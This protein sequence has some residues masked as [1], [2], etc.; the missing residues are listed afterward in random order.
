MVDFVNEDK[1]G[2]FYAKQ[3][4]TE[5]APKDGGN[6]GGDNKGGSQDNDNLSDVEKQAADDLLKYPGKTAEEIVLLKQ[7]E[8]ETAEDAAKYPGKTA[9]EIKALKAQ[10]KETAD[11]AIKYPGKTADEIKA[12]KEAEAANAETAEA[13]KAR[14]DKIEKDLKDKI[15]KELGISSP[16]EI[17]AMRDKLNAVPETPEQAAERIK[18]FNTELNAFAISNNLLSAQ[19]IT[20]I[21]TLRNQQPIDIVYKEFE[22]EYRETFKDRK[23]E[24]TEDSEPVT[25]DEIKEAFEKLYHQDSDNLALQQKGTKLMNE[26]ADTIKNQSLSKFENA[27]LEYEQELH[28]KENVPAFK[29]FMREALSGIPESIT[30]NGE[31]DDKVVFN[32]K[33]DKGKPLYDIEKINKLFVNDVFYDQFLESKDKEGLRKYVNDSIVSK[34]K[35]ENEPKIHALI[36]EQGKAAGLKEGAIG[37]KQPFNAA[38]DFKPV[39]TSDT[40]LSDVD[41][42]NLKSQFGK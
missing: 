9:D 23:Q 41:K 15:Y 33:D 2:D 11:D 4:I 29:T 12:L 16:E 19:E 10:E 18:K 7:G 38:H 28:K 30:L 5:E 42:A 26:R 22:A 17:K 27:K 37:A 3:G 34:I 25:D 13:K 20:E 6:E 14:E 36:F 24:G 8:K 40:A 21:D 31:G 32:L 39:A 1:L 35:E